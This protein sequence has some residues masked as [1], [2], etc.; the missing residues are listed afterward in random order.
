MISESRTR[1]RLRFRSVSDF[2][3]GVTQQFEVAKPGSDF[4][5]HYRQNLIG[6]WLQDDIRATSALTLNAGV[7]YEFVTTP[8]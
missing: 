5:R 6:I 1:G 3:S 4:E 2:L 7:R 8:H